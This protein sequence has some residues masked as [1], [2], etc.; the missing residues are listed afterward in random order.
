VNSFK[1]K[2]VLV[3]DDFPEFRMT[4]RQMLL[5]LKVHDI[6]MANTGEDALISCKSHVYDIILCDYNLG[7]GKDGQQLLE[8]LRALKRLK[9]TAIFIMIT[10]ETTVHMVMGAVENRPDAYLTK[11]FNSGDL[12]RRLDALVVFKAEIYE[13]NSAL[14]QED[15]VLA[16]QVCDQLVKGQSPY[17]SYATRLKAEIL[18]KLNQLED[19]KTLYQLVLKQRSQPWARL[20]VAKVLFL[21]QQ[22]I[23]S[24]QILRDLI[25]ENQ[26]NLEA[27]DLLAE[28]LMLEGQTLE[29]QNILA[30]AV[31]QSSKS[32]SRQQNLGRVAYIN[33]DLNTSIRAYRNTVELSQNGIHEDPENVI[34]YV[35]VLEEKA[36]K[37]T[38][39]NGKKAAIEGLRLL[40]EHKK[41]IR[42]NPNTEI[43]SKILEA[44]IYKIQNKTSLAEKQ[45]ADAQSL[46]LTQLESITP[47]T[48]QFLVDTL[49][50]FKE[51]DDAL[52]IYNALA[53]QQSA[54]ALNSGV[55]QE[56]LDAINQN[57]ELH[58]FRA[59]LNPDNQKG[60]SFYKEGQLDKAIEAF[61]KASQTTA[62]SLTIN[63]N[64]IQSL[65]KTMQK[66]GT[67]ED[68]LLNESKACFERI[69]DVDEKNERFTKYQE[70]KRIY[71]QLSA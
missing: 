71:N 23:E 58:E 47:K 70:L 9:N 26:N 53:S 33:K 4:I 31:K 15:L 20:G 61:Q 16:A 13:L 56:C 40:D 32:P 51:L 22:Y 63:L 64:L 55:L 62:D 11:P 67:T 41:T 66:S 8:E 29:A 5:A 21:Q 38:S 54:N 59:S 65:L 57:L 2:K 7:K 6:S 46:S 36:T 17:A 45:L 14:D 30:K 39:L 52:D 27:Y 25:F 34:D 24:A 3:V 49:C 19:A 68:S 18:I 28:I 42:A 1:D 44:R 37:D 50:S 48:A 60:V 10:A 69:G 35:R 12:Q 43:Q